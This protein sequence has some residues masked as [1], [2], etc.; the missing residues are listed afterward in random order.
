MEM[1]LL[2][3]FWTVAEVGT[4]TQAAEQL[5][6]TQP[7]LSR[8]IKNLETDL[9]T[10][11]FTRNKNHLALTQAGLFLKTRAEEILELDQQTEQ[12]FIDEK[13]QLFSGTIH[14][15]CVEADNSDTMAMILEEFIRD[16]P[17][18]KFTV[19][20]RTS[21]YV[22]DLLDKGIIDVAILLKPIDTQKYESLTL[23][24]TERWG[25]LVSKD[26][27]LA[28]KD[29]ITPNDLLDLPLIMSRRSEVSTMLEKWLG[30]PLSELNV[31]GYFNLHF[32][33]EPLV[34]RQIGVALG[35]EGAMS[36]ADHDLLKFIP[37]DPELKTNC[38]LAWARNRNLSPVASKYIR[39]FKDAFQN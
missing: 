10:P 26:A 20:T 24:R 28:Q 23:P 19:V 25:L 9:G 32:N 14:I 15:G 31:I 17:Q 12:A 21:S 1:R 11:L 2:R 18:V 4:I 6:V 39:R 30:H 27:F 33:I 7:T 13:N 34:E 16:Y 37:L 29:L 36:A 22:S 8:Q 3:Y 5:H 35:I 38:V